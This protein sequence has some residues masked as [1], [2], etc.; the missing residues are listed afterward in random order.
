MIVGIIILVILFILWKVFDPV[1]EVCSISYDKVRWL[2]VW[3]NNYTIEDKRISKY[4]TWF[5]LIKLD[6]ND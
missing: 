5:P 1:V 2:I 3:Y 6:N 4:R